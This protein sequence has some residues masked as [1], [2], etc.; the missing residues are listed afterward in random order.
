MLQRSYKWVAGVKPKNTFLMVLFSGCNNYPRI[1]LQLKL[2]CDKVGSAPNRNGHSNTCVC[3]TMPDLCFPVKPMH[4]LHIYPHIYT[5]APVC[6]CHSAVTLPK[7][8]LWVCCTS[9]VSFYVSLKCSGMEL[10]TE[11]WKLLEV[12]TIYSQEFTWTYSMCERG[13][14]CAWVRVRVRVKQLI[15]TIQPN[16]S[17]CHIFTQNCALIPAKSYFL[18][19]SQLSWRIKV[20][21]WLL[22][23]M[24]WST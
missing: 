6:P 1:I 24:P 18:K 10:Q 12:P 13:F 4:D 7:C 14:I 21:N 22:N 15:Y 16:P 8:Q 3:T 23:K 9:L 2:D 5:Y 17:V 20:G 11:Y 19:I